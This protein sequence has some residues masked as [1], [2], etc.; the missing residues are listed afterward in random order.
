MTASLPIRIAKNLH[1][2]WY[3]QV[4]RYG[5]ENPGGME[6]S[7]LCKEYGAI[8][9]KIEAKAA[10]DQSR[11]VQS[12]RHLRPFLPEEGAGVG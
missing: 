12:V 4:C 6:Y 5:R 3:F 2:F 11:M 8:Y 7:G 9:G 10:C 1:G